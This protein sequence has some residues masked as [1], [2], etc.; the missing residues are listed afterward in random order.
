[1]V[2]K[3]ALLVEAILFTKCF[4]AIM[5]LMVLNFQEIMIIAILGSTLSGIAIEICMFVINHQFTALFLEVFVN[6]IIILFY[7]FIIDTFIL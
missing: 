2:A 5:L 6:E 7:N 4:I 3:L 1:M